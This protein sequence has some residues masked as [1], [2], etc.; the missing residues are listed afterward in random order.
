MGQA[1][2]D[3]GAGEL[4][5]LRGI[6]GPP[7]VHQR[8]RVG[9]HRRGVVVVGDDEI[10]AEVPGEL[11]FGNGRHTAVDR[12]DDLRPIGGELAEGR[13]VQAVALLIA[14]RDVRAHRDPEVPECADEDGRAGDAVDVV[15]AIDDDALAG[16]E[17]TVDPVDGPVEVQHRR[18][19]V[20]Q[21]GREE[22]RHVEV[23]E[24]ARPKDLR[25]EARDTIRP[26]SAHR[27][28]GPGD[29]PAALRNEAHDH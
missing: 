5:V 14:V 6:P 29:D 13:R 23:G 25:D 15:V 8:V 22:A 9:K 19:V 21:P 10:D 7:R 4:L 16:G 27:P 24:A 28:H 18:T 17:R 20:R 2:R 1:Q 12:H 11:G 26:I 3:A